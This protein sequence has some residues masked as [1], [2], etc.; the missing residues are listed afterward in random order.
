MK[1]IALGTDHAGFRLKEAVKDHLKSN[2]F[3]VV[4][5]GTYNDEPVD[6]PDY[7][8]PAAVS[9]AKG[10]TDLGIVFGVVATG[11]PWRPTR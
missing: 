10:D 2:G 6:Y 5:Y 1:R 7:V 4:D 11:N 9:V 3:E 8:R